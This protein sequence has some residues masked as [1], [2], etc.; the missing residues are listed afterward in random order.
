MNMKSADFEHC[1][2]CAFMFLT[3]TLIHF[4]AADDVQQHVVVVAALLRL[5]A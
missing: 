3:N 1:S 2:D 4:N 5:A